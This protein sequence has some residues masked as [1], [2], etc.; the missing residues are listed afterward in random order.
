MLTLFI[1]FIP[2]F[3]IKNAI[4]DFF[5]RSTCTQNLETHYFYNFLMDRAHNKRIVEGQAK[6]AGVDDVTKRHPDYYHIV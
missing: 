3:P 2:D 4:T 1:G 6:A 5:N